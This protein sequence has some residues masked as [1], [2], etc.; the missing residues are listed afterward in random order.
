MITC[1]RLQHNNKHLLPM[2]FYMDHLISC[3]IIKIKKDTLAGGVYCSLVK[4]VLA[5]DKALFAKMILPYSSNKCVLT[6]DLFANSITWLVRLFCSSSS[7]SL[8][9]EERRVGIDSMS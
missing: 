9:S 2:S 4:Y 1:S 6:V 7:Y 8:R 5:W 3:H